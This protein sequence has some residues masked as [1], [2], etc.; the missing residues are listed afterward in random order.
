MTSR[1]HSLAKLGRLLNREE[2][3][4]VFAFM[5]VGITAIIGIA[6]FAVDVGSWYQA[7]QQ[8]Q[9]A[10]DA[11][12]TAAA[13][14]LPSR[15]TQA[16]TDASTY[17]AKNISGAT[18]TTIT[19]YS[20]DASKVKVT[21]TKSV[22]T[23]FAKIFGISSVTVS[24]SA[25][26]KSNASSNSKWAV[27]AK[28]TTCGDQS[29]SIPGASLT[30]NGPMRSN[31]DLKVS[32]ANLVVNGT[33]SYAGP[34]NCSW[35]QSGANPSFNGSSSPTIDKTNYAWPEPWTASSIPCN[36][37]YSGSVTLGTTNQTLASGVYCNPTGTFKVSAAGV[38]GTVTFVADRVQFQGANLSFRPY[39]QDLLVYNSGTSNFQWSGAGANTSGTI[40]VPQADAQVSG[41][42]GVA[43]NLFIE[44]YTV[45]ISGSGWTLNG[46]GP[47]ASGS[48]GTQ[49][50]E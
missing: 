31:G 50:I 14:D 2:G 10:A 28:D 38:N 16:A 5:A 17:A 6:A 3:G 22:P 36:Y 43:Y 11:G 12:A 24:A 9:A 7:K 4:Q 44:A 47:V 19:P 37:N 29:I 39:Y 20:G 27:F 45:H 23:F 42:S 1:I 21:V 48:T 25:A 26:A 15:A 40:Y 46:N 41:A 30:I 8:V 32:G 18:T 34:N 13:G 33:A 49:L 35:Q